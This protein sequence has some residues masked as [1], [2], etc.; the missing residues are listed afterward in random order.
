MARACMYD[1]SL[2]IDLALNH[3]KQERTFSADDVVAD[4]LEFVLV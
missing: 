2:A 4:V 3:G 1:N